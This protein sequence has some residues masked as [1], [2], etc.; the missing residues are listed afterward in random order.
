MSSTLIELRRA[1]NAR[2][3]CP[4]NGDVTLVLAGN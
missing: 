3:G 2:V 1:T 4:V